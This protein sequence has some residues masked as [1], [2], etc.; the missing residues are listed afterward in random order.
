MSPHATAGDEARSFERR[1]AWPERAASNTSL[2]TSCSCFAPGTRARQ[3]SNGSATH[4][5]QLGR[6]SSPRWH[7][8]PS[9]AC[10]RRCPRSARTSGR[11]PPVCGNQPPWWTTTW[12]TRLMWTRL[13]AALV[14]RSRGAAVFP[15]RQ[16]IG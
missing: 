16:L 3:G 1:V 13:E 7:G 5:G 12:K 10:A 4:P 2:A 9:H 11:R 14:G 6:G 15:H 8:I